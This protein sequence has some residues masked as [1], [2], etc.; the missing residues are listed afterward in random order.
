MFHT[1]TDRPTDKQKQQNSCIC[2][3]ALASSHKSSGPFFFVL[4]F[5]F[6][7][8]VLVFC[9]R[10]V[11]VCGSVYPGE[12]SVDQ[13]GLRFTE[14]PLHFAFRVLELKV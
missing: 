4:F 10:R 8:F 9:P 5:C 11:S 12:H 2:E 7:L 14:I 13:S 6:F 1:D 3:Y